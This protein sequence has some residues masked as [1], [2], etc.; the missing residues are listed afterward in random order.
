MG[1][2]GA[3]RGSQHKG[4]WLN[5]LPAQHQISPSNSTLAPKRLGRNTYKQTKK[6][7][8]PRRAN[9][10]NR[11]RPCYTPFHLHNLQASRG[12]E[13]Q[14]TLK[15]LGLGYV[16]QMLIKKEILLPI[17]CAHRRPPFPI[18][19]FLQCLVKSRV[20]VASSRKGFGVKVFYSYSQYTP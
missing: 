16:I 9:I 7:Q 8:W 5:N 11:S 12:L 14:V 4:L 20:L 10:S 6:L 1:W 3:F 15:V 18:P 17:L 13:I 19:I 2:I